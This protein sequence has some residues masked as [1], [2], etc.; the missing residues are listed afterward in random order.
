MRE[1]I[2][3]MLSCVLIDSKDLTCRVQA[4]QL[5][6]V[7]SQVSN[8]KDM[9]CATIGRYHSICRHL[10]LAYTTT[11]HTLDL[12]RGT[13]ARPSAT[14]LLLHL[15]YA[16]DFDD[17]IDRSKHFTVEDPLRPHL[18]EMEEFVDTEIP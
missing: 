9:H 7:D 14:E 5:K 3:L 8:V 13:G 11:L 18:H 2:N 1:D 4:R 16:L 10:V 12:L 17:F 15:V 6:D